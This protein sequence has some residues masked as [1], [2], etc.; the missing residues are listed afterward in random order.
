ML[1]DWFLSLLRSGIATRMAQISLQESSAASNPMTATAP[2][3]SQEQPT[4]Y[5]LLCSNPDRACQQGMDWRDN[6]AT[7]RRTAVRMPRR[8]ST[9]GGGQ[10]GTTTSTGITLATRPQLA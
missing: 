3:S 6:Y 4:E 2:N 7:R 1:N 5:L 9:G 8:M 10:P